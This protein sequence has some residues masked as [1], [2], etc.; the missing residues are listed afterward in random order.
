MS[1]FLVPASRN[2]KHVYHKVKCNMWSDFPKKLIFWSK[3]IRKCLILMSTVLFKEQ[4][5]LANL[6]KHKLKISVLFVWLWSKG[7]LFTYRCF[8]FTYSS[9][10]QCFVIRLSAVCVPLKIKTC[11]QF[12]WQSTEDN[13]PGAKQPGKF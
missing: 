3:L 6:K 2:R 8:D 4:K 10:I 13:C 11:G 9:H 7:R 1:V 12:E 5:R